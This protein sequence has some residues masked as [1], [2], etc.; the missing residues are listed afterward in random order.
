MF[1]NKAAVVSMVVLSVITIMAILAPLLSPWAYDEPNWEYD[2]PGA[3]HAGHKHWFGTD[4]NGR[5]LFVHT[6]YGARISL[7]VGILATGISLLIGVT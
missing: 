5:D 7:M 6:L 3:P 4:G 1:R 2:F